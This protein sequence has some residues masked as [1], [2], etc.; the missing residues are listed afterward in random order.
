MARKKKDKVGIK[1]GVVYD[2]TSKESYGT[3]NEALRREADCGCGIDCCNRELKL[4]DQ[5]TDAIYALYFKDGHMYFRDAE[6][7]EYKVSVEP[8]GET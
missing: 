6:G 3:L 1:T 7:Q 8:T 4:E 2:I 5:S